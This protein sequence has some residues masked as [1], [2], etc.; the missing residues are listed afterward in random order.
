[1]SAEENKTV[2]V[3]ENSSPAPIAEA[4]DTISKVH[5]LQQRFFK[6]CGELFE[7]MEYIG[8]PMYNLML[9]HYFVQYKREYDLMNA[10]EFIEVDR[11]IEQLKIERD[12]ELE[13]VKLERDKN[14]KLL[15]MQREKEIKEIDLERAKLSETL[16]TIRERE[17]EAVK[18][19]HKELTAEIERKREKLNN[20]IE[21]LAETA[22]LEARIKADRIIPNFWRRFHIGKLSFGR[23][24]KNEAMQYAEQAA[25]NEINEYLTMRAQEVYQIPVADDEEDDEGGEGEPE[26]EFKTEQQQHTMTKRE[27]KQWEKRFEKEL[28]KRREE[29]QKQ[30]EQ[31]MQEEP[32]N[33]EQELETGVAGGAETPDENG[34]PAAENTTLIVENK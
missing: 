20:E 13:A 3:A 1:M 27:Y 26:P 10:A 21:I 33:D 5:K 4:N 2:L 16:A 15:D 22:Y 17:L 24:C 34:E 23:V 6:V 28:R 11:Q 14:K 7:Y 19:E 9:E 18:L 30:I 25:S 31:I 8:E 32:A 29:A 12:K